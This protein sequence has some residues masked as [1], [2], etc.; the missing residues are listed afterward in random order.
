MPCFFMISSKNS[1]WL[2]WQS[3]IVP[4]FAVVV[5]SLALVISI[6]QPS[7]FSWY[8]E[9]DKFSFEESLA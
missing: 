5:L 2:C 4:G 6:C 8:M 1:R 7:T 3:V 9:D